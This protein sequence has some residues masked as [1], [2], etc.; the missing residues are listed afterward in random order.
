MATHTH[1]TLQIQL[2]EEQLEGLKLLAQQWDVS[3]EDL[4]SQSVDALLAENQIPG[5]PLTGIIGMFNS[6]V[7]DLA[8]NHDQYLVDYERERNGSWPEKSS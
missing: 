3:L 1:A 6:G 8:E 5:H 4:I 7:G 2:R